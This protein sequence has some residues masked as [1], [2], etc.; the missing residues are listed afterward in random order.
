[1]SDAAN[2]AL[3]GGQPPSDDAC[4]EPDPSNYPAKEAQP[5]AEDLD[6]A[7]QSAQAAAIAQGKI[8]AVSEGDYLDKLAELAPALL[9]VRKNI[10]QRQKGYK[11]GRRNGA[12]NWGKWLKLWRAETGVKLCDKT[13]KRV[14]DELDQIKPAPRPKTP[15]VKAIATS[16]QKK[17]GLA[18]LAVREMLDNVNEQGAVILK[19]EDIAVLR[20]ILPAAAVLDRLVSNL[21]DEEIAEPSQVASATAPGPSETANTAPANQSPD[22]SP[23]PDLKSGDA[24]L[25]SSRVIQQYGP[26]LRAVA[27]DLPPSK[28]V[29]IIYGVARG[30]AMELSGPGIGGFSIKVD[31][32]PPKR[33]AS[34]QPKPAEDDRQQ[35]FFEM[36]APNSQAELEK[37]AS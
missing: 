21:P 27:G 35:S 14:L 7:F 30:V 25:L 29:G 13:I 26:A 31:H 10:H 20:Q 22:E 11:K 36:S 1:M 6:A 32:I 8:F 18:L 3:K 34:G 2:S 19:K 28:R 9:E 4:P 33:E 37:I 12:P 17:M 24:A 23:L 5:E 16:L 15:L